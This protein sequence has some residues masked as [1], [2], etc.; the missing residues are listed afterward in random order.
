MDFHVCMTVFPIKI[1]CTYTSI[2]TLAL[3]YSFVT[4][5][6]QK[7]FKYQYISLNKNTVHK[8]NCIYLKIFF[9]LKIYYFNSLF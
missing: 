6:Q 2:L 7:Y 3:N 8:S 9:S 4:G 5:I 1:L